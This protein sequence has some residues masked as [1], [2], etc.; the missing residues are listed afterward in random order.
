M[1][2]VSI[3]WQRSPKISQLANDQKLSHTKQAERNSFPRKILTKA[4]VTGGI[5]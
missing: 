1:V 2:L 5:W 4:E 3:R